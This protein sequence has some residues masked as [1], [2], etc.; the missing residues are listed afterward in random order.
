VDA[1]TFRHLGVK[2]ALATASAASGDPAALFD[3]LV[4]AAA[5]Q[6]LSMS[7]TKPATML[8]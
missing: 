8:A 4:C 7:A 3:A 6:M 5:W 2:Q 1:E